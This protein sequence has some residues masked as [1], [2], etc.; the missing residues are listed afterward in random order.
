MKNEMYKYATTANINELSGAI[1]SVNNN[2]TALSAKTI[3]G[4]DLGTIIFDGQSIEASTSAVTQVADTAA[5]TNYDSVSVNT[6]PNYPYST[7]KYTFGQYTNHVQ[8]IYGNWTHTEYIDGTPQSVTTIPSTYD[9][10]NLTM[11]G[12]GEG[13]LSGIKS[14]VVELALKSDLP[15][16]EYDSSNKISAINGSA[17]AGGTSDEDVNTL[18]HTNSA[19]WNTVSDK[20]DTTAFSDVS[21]N[22]LTAHQDLSDYQTTAGMTAYQP[23]GDYLTT[24]DSA[25][26]YT[27]ANESGFITGVNLSGISADLA[28][29]MGVDETL[30]WSGTL[31]ATG[32]NFVLS[33]SYK[34]FN[35]FKMC[36]NMDD[37]HQEIYVNITTIN[38]AY[39]FSWGQTNPTDCYV[40]WIGLGFSTDTTGS[41]VRSKALNYLNSTTSVSPNQCRNNWEWTCRALTAIYGIGRKS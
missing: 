30:L 34:N 17:I 26:F 27:T 4:S 9:G 22:F 8:A 7:Y 38:T 11:V 37:G 28:R 6:L 39:G 23:V 24:A 36:L 33:E 29:M 3:T 35:K 32:Q 12:F 40:N 15:T 14:D 21:G 20:L 25:E 10:Y 41:I 1:S 2:L 31:T 19:T 18:V 5:T 16:Y 13:V